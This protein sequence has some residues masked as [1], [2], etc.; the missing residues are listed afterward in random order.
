MIMCENTIY[1][2]SKFLH[3]AHFVVLSN[4]VEETESRLRKAIGCN[5]I[6]V[7]PRTTSFH[8]KK[9]QKGIS[10]LTDQALLRYRNV[11]NS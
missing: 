9:V 6:E 2:L 11:S 4:L 7:R 1:Y 8:T 5:Q 3:D 10:I